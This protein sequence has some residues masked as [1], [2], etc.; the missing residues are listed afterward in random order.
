MKQLFL[1]TVSLLLAMSVFS[2]NITGAWNG[3]LNAGGQKIP[4]VI[5]IAEKDGV[6]SATMDSPAQGAKGIPISTVNFENG[7]LT[8]SIANLGVEYEGVWQNDSIVGTFKQSGMSLPLTFFPVKENSTLLA[9]PQ[10]PKPPYP[11]NSEDVK[12]ENKAAGITLAGTLTLPKEGKNFPVAVLVTGSGAQNRNEEIVNHRPFLVLSDYL[13]RNGIAVL[14][15]DD[16]GVAESGGKY[17]TATI[18]DFAS[19][20]AAAVNYLKTRKEINPKKIGIIGHSEGGTIAFMLASEKNNDLAF[21]VSMA[22]MAIRGD[23][24]LKAQQYALLTAQ[25]ASTAAIAQNEELVA[26]M[27]AVINKHAADSVFLNPNQYVSEAIP[28]FLQGNSTATQTLIPQLK[29]LASPEIQS[30]QKCNPAEFLPKIKCP[31]L[32]LGG[33]KDLQVPADI[34]LDRIKALVKS[35]VTI[36][37]YPN[38]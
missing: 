11:Y 14:R 35:P 9:R 28:A 37:K 29:W 10:D 6:Y 1:L 38:L 26:Q 2:Q 4:L 36:K 27:Q 34:N 18:D 16:R 25:G 33:E 21:I 23:S 30:L 12:F 19:D 31:V 20:A 13:T 3:V 8:F 32:A 22:G 17:E 7:K 5:N 15:C 24:L